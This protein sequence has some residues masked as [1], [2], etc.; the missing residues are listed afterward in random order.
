ML[1]VKLN[2]GL[3]D[4]AAT[5]QMHTGWVFWQLGRRQEMPEKKKKK[6]YIIIMWSHICER[7]ENLLRFNDKTNDQKVT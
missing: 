4:R 3:K 1:T 6:S 5:W 2:L 7:K